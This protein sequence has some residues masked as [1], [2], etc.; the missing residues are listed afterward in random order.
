MP[1]PLP[2]EPPTARGVPAPEDPRRL[3]C[4]VGALL[5]QRGFIMATDGNLSVRLDRDRILASPTGLSKGMLEPD[6][7]VVVDLQG[8]VLEGRYAPSSELPMHL[9]IYRSRPDVGGVCHAHPPVATGF[10]AAGV[11]LDKALLAETV[12]ALQQIPLARYATPGTRELAETLAPLIARHNAILMANHGVVTC[13]PDLQTAYFHMEQVEHLARVTLITE[14]L[15]RQA[16]LRPNDVQRLLALRQGAP[17]QDNH[18]SD[19]SAGMRQRVEALL[20]QALR[21]LQ[22]DR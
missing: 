3:L 7:L 8:R 22:Q 15:G 6:D 19:A 18:E 20:R 2:T 12:V 11:P 16:Q 10:A 1:E 21:L 9:L 13:G 14:L 17:S 5:Y 4:R